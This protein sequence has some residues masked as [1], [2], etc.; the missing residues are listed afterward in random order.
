M[1]GNYIPNKKF[2]F[3]QCQPPWVNDKIKRCLKERKKINQIL[4]KKRAKERSLRKIGSKSC[5]L[6]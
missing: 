1:L 5:I 2:E 6:H 4:F 3:N